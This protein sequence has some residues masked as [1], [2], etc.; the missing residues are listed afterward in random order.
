MPARQRS[1]RRVVESA[2][3]PA[4][5]ERTSSIIEPSEPVPSAIVETEPPTSVVARGTAPRTTLP[6]ASGTGLPATTT[7]AVAS[8]EQPAGGNNMLVLDTSARKG[9]WAYYAEDYARLRGCSLGDRGAVLLQETDTFELHE[10][11]CAGAAN[12]LVKCQGGICQAMR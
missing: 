9:L 4:R 12:M 1:S 2:P 7:P 8:R 3:A 10:V 5:S 6:P 11:E